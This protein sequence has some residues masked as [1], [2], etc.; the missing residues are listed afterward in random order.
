MQHNMSTQQLTVD[1]TWTPPPPPLTRAQLDVASR[2]YGPGIVAFC[3]AHVGEQVGNGECWTLAQQAFAAA[4]AQEPRG[5]NY[6][7]EID[8]A[9]VQPGDVVHF[10]KAR[11]EGRT[12]DG[13][14]YWSTAGNPTHTAVVQSIKAGPDVHVW[15]QNSGGRRTVG[16]GIFKMRDLVSGRVSYWR[17]IPLLV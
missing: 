3:Q 9:Q 4:G 6:G 17:A 11:F 13:G 16:H 8:L 14:T 7:Q 15:E 2:E 12:P 1:E 10:E 5:T